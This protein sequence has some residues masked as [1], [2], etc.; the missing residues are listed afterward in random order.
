MTKIPYFSE[1]N[2]SAQKLVQTLFTPTQQR[3]VVGIIAAGYQT[4]K[5]FVSVNAPE[6]LQM[7]RA[8]KLYPELKNM[9]VEFSLRRACDQKIIP[10]SYGIG[11][12]EKNKNK[13]LKLINNEKQVILT[14][15]QIPSDR[16]ASR[17]AKFRADLFDQCDNRFVLFD[18]E[19]RSQDSVYLELNHGYQ[20]DQP[21]FTILGKPDSTGLWE[22]RLN[23]QNN[24]Q[25]LSSNEEKDIKTTAK[26]VA[27][28]S[29][30]EF[31][32][33]QEFKTEG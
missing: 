24:L 13:F 16:R 32:Q 30:D 15:N 20:S 8:Q 28:F 25:V 19:A 31:R 12:I 1:S 33:Y 22:A 17:H 29:M 3:L 21:S 9:A 26:E 10:F 27:S 6:W 2:K 4:E 23:L 5:H 14:I 18:D 11:T 7:D